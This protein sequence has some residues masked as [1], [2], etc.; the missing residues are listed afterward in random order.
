[1]TEL[2]RQLD[3]LHTCNTAL[4]GLERQLES[5]PR[6]VDGIEAKLQAVRDTTESGR[7]ALDSSEQ[8]RRS[9]EGQ[10]QDLQ[11]QREKFQ[12]QTALVKTNEEYTA[13]LN[14]IDVA[15][16]RISE[17]EDEILVAMEQI[18]EGRELLV[19]LERDQDQAERELGK[20]IE[21]RRRDLAEAE[22]QLTLRQGENEVLVDRLAPEVRSLYERVRGRFSD[23]TTRIKL[24]DC[25]ACHFNVPFETINRVK[26]GELHP[27]PHCAR[28][29][30]ADSD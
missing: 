13:L 6:E 24:R 20:E 1:M 30:V 8:E 10:L 22:S 12:G 19:G 3:E 16:R 5:I 11:A 25:S 9:K 27:C 23:P 29:L 21:A 28:I 15:T 18:E 4:A 7:E 14:E 17:T 2:M 26:Q